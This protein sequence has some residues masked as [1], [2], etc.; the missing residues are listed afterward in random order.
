MTR[1]ANC[2]SFVA[3]KKKK[4]KKAFVMCW[5]VFSNQKH[6]EALLAPSCLCACVD[7]QTVNVCMMCGS[8]RLSLQIGSYSSNKSASK[9]TSVCHYNGTTVCNPHKFNLQ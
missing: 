7:P 2:T 1:I 8:R 4:I 3:D 6:L 9:G 5:W